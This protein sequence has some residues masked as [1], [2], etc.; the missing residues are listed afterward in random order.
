MRAVHHQRGGEPAGGVVRLLEG[1]LRRDRRATRHQG[2][3]LVPQA[4]HVRGAVLRGDA[5]FSCVCVVA[6]TRSLSAW[7]AFFTYIYGV[8]FAFCA[9]PPV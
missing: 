4:A 8:S 3:T 9:V 5:V 1:Y 2:G 7:R 6:P